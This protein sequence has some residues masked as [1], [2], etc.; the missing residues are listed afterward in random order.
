[1]DEYER[2]EICNAVLVRNI[3]TDIIYCKL[4]GWSKN[5]E[6]IDENPKYIG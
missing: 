1:M 3:L 5:K 6:S 4:C 2:C